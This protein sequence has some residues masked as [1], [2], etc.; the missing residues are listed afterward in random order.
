MPLIK[1]TR[2]LPLLLMLFTLTSCDLLLGPMLDGAG[3]APDK[4]EGL[5]L[6]LR[7]DKG[8]YDDIC[9]GTPA[10]D[11]S[12]VLCWQDQSGKNNHAA[13]AMAPFWHK[14]GPLD[15]KASVYFPT[16]S[17]LTGN[18]SGMISTTI[19]TLT[20]PTSTFAS[21]GFIFLLSGP[22]IRQQ[23][24]GIVDPTFQFLVSDGTVFTGKGINNKTIFTGLYD[25]FN[26]KA[27]VNGASAGSSVASP[28]VVSTLYTIGDPQYF[29]GHIAEIL[30][31]NRALSDSERQDVE[32][33]L[34]K[35]YGIDP[36]E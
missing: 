17:S 3:Q 23:I 16:T 12:G 36:A 8:V 1:T 11:G 20:Y 33:Y 24:G 15:G 34:G 25:G 10:Q 21:E 14:S 6:W 28:L 4:I 9:G 26:I 32:S 31:Y 18:L 35:K 5:S 19:I 29:E 22:D 13:S 27:F 30:V 7:A 2:L